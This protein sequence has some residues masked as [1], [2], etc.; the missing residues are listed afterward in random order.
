[1]E[2]KQQLE[3]SLAATVRNGS[4]VNS[5]N[6]IQILVRNWTLWLLQLIPAWK[7]R[8]ELGP[9]GEGPVQYMHAEGMPFIPEL[10]GGS[11]FPQTYCVPLGNGSQVQFTD[12]AIFRDGKSKLFQVVVL[13]DGL[14]DLST[15]IDA[16]AGIGHLIDELS[17]EECTVFVPRHSLP[18][19]S[20][21]GA[22][23]QLDNRL[24]RTATDG[25]FAKSNLCLN[26]A[27]P[28]GYDET[29]MWKGMKG[30]RFIILRPDRFVFAACRT[31]SELELAASILA[32]FISS[33]SLHWLA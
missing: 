8:L 1:M 20:G 32:Q 4:I 13:I 31:K 3:K 24:F 9:K 11:N 10:L 14:D 16:V 7:H 33:G 12:D 5:R 22:H 30:S 23:T 21:E 18:M 15:A 26:R 27:I 17:V 6:H 29:L 28:R 19:L 2:R 25:E